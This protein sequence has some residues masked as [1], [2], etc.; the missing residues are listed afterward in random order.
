MSRPKE[1]SVFGLTVQSEVDLPELLPT[2]ISGE[3]DVAIRNAPV[4]VP[5][6]LRP[7]VQADG[8]SVLLNIPN[9][10]R[11]LIE[12]GAAI[13]VDPVTGVDDRN[14]RL[15]LLGSAFGLLL[16]QRGLLPLHANCVEIAG[17]AIAFMGRSGSG[18]STLASWFYDQGFRV[19]SDDVCV[20]DFGSGGQPCVRPGIARLRLWRDALTATGRTA[21]EHEP[22]FIGDGAPDKFDVSLAQMASADT[23]L[24]LAAVYV[25][26]RGETQQIR[27]IAGSAAVDAVFANTYRGD[28]IETV[29][30]SRDHWAATV[31]L[32]QHVP[33]FH[34]DRRWGLPDLDEQSAALLRHAK[35]VAGGSMPGSKSA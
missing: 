4:R 17:T 31:K 24:P 15:Y 16:H 29:G 23:S 6:D 13:T 5:A 9:V 18:K 22:S 7:G 3:A 19:L 8:D 25:L 20:V 32:V 35:D 12:D 28:Y 26:D 21:S 27:P 1:Y 2:V 30:S 34:A 33:I 11:Y 10:A 14:V